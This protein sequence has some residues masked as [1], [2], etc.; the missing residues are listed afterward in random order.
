MKILPFAYLDSLY[1]HFSVKI[2]DLE[3]SYPQHFTFYATVILLR[4]EG[5]DYD[6]LF[7][8]GNG[9][10]SSVCGN[11]SQQTYSPDVKSAY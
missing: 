10:A 1:S 3:K 4:N 11:R 5:N 9:S 6:K 7:R 2:S 8:S